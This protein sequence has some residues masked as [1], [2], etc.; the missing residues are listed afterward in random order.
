M[1]PAEIAYILNRLSERQKRSFVA[2]TETEILDCAKNVLQELRYLSQGLNRE[3]IKRPRNRRNEFKLALGN[4]EDL[5][6]PYTRFLRA[7]KSGNPP[8]Q[9]LIPSEVSQL[10]EKL[11]ILFWK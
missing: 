11:E 6:V 9:H 2:K 10:K 3:A 8:F 1:L 7:I 4:I 5:I